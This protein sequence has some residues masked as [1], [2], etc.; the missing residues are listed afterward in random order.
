[1]P[2]KFSL[3]MPFLKEGV[4]SRIEITLDMN[5]ITIIC[6]CHINYNPKAITAAVHTIVK[7]KGTN[8]VVTN[9]NL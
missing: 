4:V 1:M 2:I 9:T 8:T 6:F 3:V 7:I 5:H